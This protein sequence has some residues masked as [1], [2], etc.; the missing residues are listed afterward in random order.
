MQQESLGQ[1]VQPIARRVQVAGDLHQGMI[2]QAEERT[3]QR[4]AVKFADRRQLVE[5][6]VGHDWQ[7]QHEA[8]VRLIEH[9]PDLPVDI[10]VVSLH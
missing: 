6:A 9:L 4:C 2:D 8:T 1:A 3:L 7:G 5:S 10:G